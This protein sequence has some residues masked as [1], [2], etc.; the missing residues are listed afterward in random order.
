MGDDKI[1][2]NESDELKSENDD[3]SNDVND[4][5]GIRQPNATISTGRLGL[6]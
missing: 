5:Q 4:S 6:A 3:P 1:V 2:T